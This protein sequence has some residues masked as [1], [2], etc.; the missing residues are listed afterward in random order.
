ML[1]TQLQS[2][3]RKL[4]LTRV[5][6]LWLASAVAA[7][8]QGAL[9]SYLEVRLSPDG[10]HLASVEGDQSAAGGAPVVR[11]LVL[12]R[13]DGA[14][15]ASVTLPCGR[16]AQ[17]WPAALAWAPDG[18]SL[19]FAL[20]RPGSHARSL[21]RVGA[22]GTGLTELLAFDG[23]LDALRYGRDGRLAL[24]ATAGATKELGAVE[25]GAPMLGDLADAIPEQRIAVVD[26]QGLHWMSPPDLFVYEY[27]WLPDGSGFVGTAAPGDGDNNWW[28]ACLYSFADGAGK[29]IYTP[30][31]ARHQIAEPTVLPDGRHVAFIGGIMSDFG[32]TGGDVYSL[33]RDSGKVMDLTPGFGASATALTVRC[34]GHLLAQVLAGDASELLDVGNAS[35]A[36]A[37]KVWSGSDSIGG[38]RSES[39]PSGRQAV[40]RQSFTTPPEIAVGRLGDWASVTH[41]NQGRTLPATARSVTWSSDGLSVQGWLLLPASKVGVRLPMVTVVHGGPAAA[42]QPVFWGAGLER[43]L[44]ERGYALFLPNPRGSFGQGETFTQANVKDFGHGDLRD[45]LA[46]IDAVEMTAPIDDARLGLYGHSYGG[47]M[48]MWSVTQTQR[49]AAAVAGAGIANWQSYYGQNGIDQ[50]MI[51]YFGESVYDDPAVYARSAP[52]TYIKNVKTPTLTY[53]GALDVECPA[54][55]TLEF[56]HALKAFGVA[57]SMVIYAGEGHAIRDPTN[58]ADQEKRVL[59]WFDRYLK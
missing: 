43:S 55:Q 54:A 27:D 35:G 7:A 8:S 36:A 49:F 23:T 56:D 37:K 38:L 24:L 20:R 50:W 2:E 28:V 5:V 22:D 46:G 29:L 41:A 10:T 59:G 4:T 34:D 13:A 14:R 51:P 19:A 42:T 12:R 40:V 47:F 3:M 6:A 58:L 11:D 48:T 53:V 21:Y 31:D 44:L 18:K 25:A 33:E 52:I 16:V 15:I 39:C 17:C 1:V 32:S 9:H 45:I 57:S 30:P 26:E